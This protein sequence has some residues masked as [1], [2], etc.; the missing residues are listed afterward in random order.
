MSLFS[1]GRR[2]PE[3]IDP[4]IEKLRVA[5]KANPELRL[6]QLVYNLANPNP[7]RQGSFFN[8]EDD[9]LKWHLVPCLDPEWEGG[10]WLKPE[11][12]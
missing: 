9:E 4:I 6:T 10:Y 12:E 1:G 11:V 3:R 7:L 2:N 8:M 5:W